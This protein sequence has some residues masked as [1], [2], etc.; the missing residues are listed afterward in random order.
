MSNL[1]LKC[2]YVFQ[3][4]QDLTGPNFEL[5]EALLAAFS[6]LPE[7]ALPPRPGAGSPR[8]CGG[9]LPVLSAPRVPCCGGRQAVYPRGEREEEQFLSRESGFV[10]H[11]SLHPPVCPRASHPQHRSHLRAW[12]A[13]P[14]GRET[15][16]ASALPSY[17]QLFS[18]DHCLL[19]RTPNAQR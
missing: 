1:F 12:N 2:P 5:T 18:R 15:G 10:V 11:L 16:P 4:L 9:Q 14:H 17:C 19:S 3:W 13:G 8:S 7:V 6:Q